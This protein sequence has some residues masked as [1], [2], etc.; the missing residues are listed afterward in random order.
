MD[1]L[2]ARTIAMDLGDEGEHEYY[3]AGLENVLASAGIVTSAALPPEHDPI[4]HTGVGV[5]VSGVSTKPIV[6]EDSLWGDP[7][8]VEDKKKK[9]TGNTLLCELHG[10]V[11]SRGICKVYEK[12]KKE[13]DSQDRRNGTGGPN[14]GRGGRGG[15]GAVRGTRGIPPR[16]RGGFFKDPGPRSPNNG[17]FCR[18]YFYGAPR[19]NRSVV[20]TK[21]P[22]KANG[23]ASPKNVQNK[24]SNDAK[25]KAKANTAWGANNNAWSRSETGESAG[26]PEKLSPNPS[27]K[28][29]GSDDDGPWNPPAAKGWTQ[30]EID[31]GSQADPWSVPVKVEN[32]PRGKDTGLGK[33]RNTNPVGRGVL[34]KAPVKPAWGNTG[35][36]KDWTPSELGLDDSVSQRGG[37]FRT[38][39]NLEPGK[40]SWAD[41]VEDEF[42]YASGNEPSPVAGPA[43]GLEGDGDGADDGWVQGGKGKGKGKGQ[44]KAKSATG[45]SDVTNQGIW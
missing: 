20:E 42:D 25:D 23:R 21:P 33:T 34:P 28:E 35:G 15:R 39:P 22:E 18:G 27:A 14:N 26:P 13:Q 5:H 44:G 1:E 37:G 4:D 32:K 16:G 38:P 43:P 9:K 2:V 24:P 40:K 10:K 31:G 17:E 3:G 7:M 12:Q 19:L 29:D 6:V 41:Q 8:E 36:A 45:W 11:C 30:S